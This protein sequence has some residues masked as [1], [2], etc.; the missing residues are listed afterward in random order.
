MNAPQEAMALIDRLTQNGFAAYFVGGCVRDAIRGVSPKD[1]DIATAATPDEMLALFS[2]Y[3]VIMTGI[4]HGTVTVLAEGKPYELT[5]FR[6]DGE[7]PDNRH[8]AAVSFTRDFQSDA[9]RRDFTMNAIGYHPK[10][11]LVDHYGGVEDIQN[12]RICAVGDPDLRF[13]EDALRILRALRFAATLG[14]AIEKE[15]AAALRKKAHL[16][17]HVS[18]ERI[19][20]EFSKLLLGDFASEILFEYREVIA[21]FLPEIR[22]MFDLDQRNPHHIFDVYRHT[23]RVLSHTEK[24]LVLRLSAFFHDIGKPECFFTD[25]NGMGHFYGHEKKSHEI[26]KQALQ[27]LRYDN[28]TVEAVA[29]LCERHG[30]PILT[31]DAWLKKQLSRYGEEAFFRL[32]ALKKADLLSLV[33]GK[34]ARI[35][36]LET[37]FCRARE[38][39]AEKPCLSLRDLAVKGADLLACGVPQGKELGQKLALL[40]DAVLEGQVKN[41]RD[42]LLAYITAIEKNDCI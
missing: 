34:E 14:F 27:N 3:R 20:D 31:S 12:R 16:L 24:D 7:Y 15:T 35:S 28:K 40:L 21:T 13:T 17:S 6:I 33:S 37:A 32:L 9:A 10:L 1:Y 41:E 18:K 5:S 30:I 23:L 19:R 26:V 4:R 29:L 11:G 2:D 39:L 25:E 42:A 38:I 8:P 36:E 22:P